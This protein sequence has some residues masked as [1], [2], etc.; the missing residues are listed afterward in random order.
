MKGTAKDAGLANKTRQLRKK[1]V[2]MG[3]LEGLRE[4]SYWVKRIFK[5]WVFVFSR[6][7]GERDRL[8][9]RSA[10]VIDKSFAPRPGRLLFRS[11]HLCGRT[12]KIPSIFRCFRQYCRV[13]ILF[14]ISTAFVLSL[15]AFGK[16]PADH[17]FFKG[18]TL[19]KTYTIKGA[20]IRM[21]STAK[22]FATL[23]LELKE[24]LGEGWVT[25]EPKEIK[26]PTIRKKAEESGLNPGDS[27]IYVVPTSPELKVSLSLTKLPGTEK[28]EFI[29]ILTIARDFAGN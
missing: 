7:Q 18:E 14:A 6:L 2:F 23:N 20:S 25:E 15:T 24:L 3:T 21:I 5:K 28:G 8:R 19:V 13:R 27:V 29:A 26:N 11:V 1:D 22:D 10:R 12:G 16:L 4:I 17:Q 9:R